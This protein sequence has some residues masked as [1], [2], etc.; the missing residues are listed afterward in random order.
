MALTFESVMM[1]KFLK[2]HT[3]FLFIYLF[4][5]IIINIDV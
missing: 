2:F 4:L 1:Q 5:Q 3:N